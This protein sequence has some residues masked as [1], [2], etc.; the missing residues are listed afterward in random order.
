MTSL[1]RPSSRD[2]CALYTTRILG[3]D[4]APV[5]GGWAWD[6]PHV[7]WA[8]YRYANIALSQQGEVILPTLRRAVVP[9]VSTQIVDGDW[10]QTPAQGAALFLGALARA[11][12]TEHIVTALQWFAT[13]SDRRFARYISAA[14]HPLPSEYAAERLVVNDAGCLEFKDRETGAVH[15]SEPSPLHWPRQALWD[16]CNGDYTALWPYCV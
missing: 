11:T 2:A 3:A 12:T 10:Q 14:G 1:N 13:Q 8:S 9:L 6:L 15:L 5:S 16:A 7:R 4:N